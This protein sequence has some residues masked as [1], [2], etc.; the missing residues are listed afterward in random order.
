M[1]GK[2]LSLIVFCLFLSGC[3]TTQKSAK[4]DLQDMQSR[5]V[6][7]EDEMSVKDQRIVSIQDELKEL[8]Q[9]CMRKYDAPDISSS[10][11]NDQPFSVSKV[12]SS[13][14]TEVIRVDDVSANQVQ[15]ALKNAGFYDGAV[16]GKIGSKTKE[17]IKAFQK[18]NN[19]TAD[20]VVGR[21]T[22]VKL[23]NHL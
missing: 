18:A 20:G 4:V 16:D 9:E 12:N 3:A 2:R 22:W 8:K 6:F 17:G 5:I 1:M 19:L 13:T 23:K 14:F 21:G 7:L 15:L 10:R 11:K